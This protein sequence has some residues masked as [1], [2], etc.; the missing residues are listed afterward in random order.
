MRIYARGNATTSVFLLLRSKANMSYLD[1]GSGPSPSDLFRLRQHRGRRRLP[2]LVG[3]LWRPIRRPRQL[4]LA[5][6][7]TGQAGRD[8]TGATLH[9]L[10]S[11]ALGRFCSTVVVPFGGQR[12]SETTAILLAVSV[13]LLLRL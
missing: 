13:M 5:V 1:L 10:I 8:R 6:D 12:R 7:L 2:L 9:G 4:L 3:R 11:S